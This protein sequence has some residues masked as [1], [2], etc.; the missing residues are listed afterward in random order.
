MPV[1]RLS[2]MAK[3]AGMVLPFFPGAE[4]YRR[5]AAH[6]PVIRKIVTVVTLKRLSITW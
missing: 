5:F 2:G 3:K 4:K 1:T 6:F